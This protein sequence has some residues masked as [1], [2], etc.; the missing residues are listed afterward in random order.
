MLQEA[1]VCS[2]PTRIVNLL[3]KIVDT[4]SETEIC[5]A[6]PFQF[7]LIHYKFPVSTAQTGKD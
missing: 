4:V 2:V 5:Q 1:A 6:K 7:C 3:L